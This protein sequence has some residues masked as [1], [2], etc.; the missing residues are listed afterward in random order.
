MDQTG[1]PQDT[2]MGGSAK[3]DLPAEFT[4][5]RDASTPVTVVETANGIDSGFVGPLPVLSQTLDLAAMTADHKVN[6][7]ADYCPG[8]VGMARAQDP[9]SGNSQFFLMRAYHGSLDKQYTAVG[10]VIAGM[11]VVRA[12]KTG[13][14]VA[15]P[16]DRMTTVR[17]LADLPPGQRPGVRVIDPAGP[18]FQT[19]VRRVAAEKVIGF[20]PCDLDIPSQLK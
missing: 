13:E 17:V 11:D 19:Q 16:Q 5:R 10:R 7:W 20:S 1:D 12:I 8:V 6:A 14:P 4:F 9:N 15:A 18:W 3:P 2:G